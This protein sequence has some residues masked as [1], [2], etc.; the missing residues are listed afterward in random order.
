MK[1]IKFLWLSLALVMLTLS[2]SVFA[3]TT[4]AEITSSVETKIAADNTLSGQDIKVSTKNGVVSLTGTVENNA[5]AGQ[6][7]ELASSV[8]G[9][10]DTKVT[11]L[12]ISESSEQPFADTAITAKVKGTFIR[13]KL[14]GDKDVSAMGVSV[15]TT[16]GIVHLSGTVDNRTQADNAIKLARSVSGVKKVESTIEVKPAN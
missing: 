4:D 12:K 13:E 5:Q 14:F 11:D 9:V 7:V 10:K 1:L 8:S 3:K 6:A 15:E 16:N 2:Q